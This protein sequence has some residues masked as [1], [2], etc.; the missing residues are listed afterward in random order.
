MSLFISLR[1]LALLSVLVFVFLTGY[2][3]SALLDLQDQ[4]SA[5]LG[6]NMVWA[7]AQA[8]HQAALF[9]QAAGGIGGSGHRGNA[10]LQRELLRAR[11]QIFRAPTQQAF[12]ERAGVLGLLDELDGMLAAT[13]PDYDGLQLTLHE[14]GRKI[15][16]TEREQA[17]ERRDAYKQLM[18]QLI[19]FVLG[20]MVSGAV[21]CW[22]LLRSI[23]S[24]R[25]GRDEIA[26]QHAQ[27]Q[28]LL[29]AL[30]RERE[31]RLRYRDF[32]S[33]MSHQLR[34]PLAVVDSSAQRLSRE[35]RGSE[36]GEAVARRTERIRR[37]VRQLNVLI[38]RVLQ[39]LRIDEQGEGRAANL[40]L[41]RCDWAQIIT[42]TLDGFDELL[43]TRP[44]RLRWAER[45]RPPLWIRCDRL[46]C[47]EL[48]ANLI[49]NADKHSPAG[50][51]IEIEVSSEAGWLEC[52]LCDSG[53][54]IPDD[55]L[56]RIFERFYRGG[57]SGQDAGIGL[58]LPIART[59]ARWHGGT[60]EA[61]N[62]PEGGACFCL[63]LPLDGPEA[64]REQAAPAAD[65]LVY[66]P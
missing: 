16:Q 44:V 45:A 53:P 62:R 65:E 66:H 35:S 64:Q 6:E 30:Q 47:G 11:M 24:I 31:T 5:D 51:P 3:L 23:R 13:P 26:R 37:A 27:A 28:Q 10:M 34:T 7:S 25:E 17:G 40:Q 58:G 15:M 4:L 38:S 9:K 55:E 36:L 43:A 41:A 21:L 14:V 56:G 1:R 50:L 2:T 39:G 52:R 18:R 60:L 63:R 29:D 46:W 8:S 32:V 48:L 49:S 33:L 19:F 57:N 20:V 12:M 59:L 54:G 42:R 61:S 22:Q